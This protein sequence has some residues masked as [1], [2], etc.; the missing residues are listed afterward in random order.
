MKTQNFTKSF[1]VLAIA[2]LLAVSTAN[3][4]YASAKPSG[5]KLTVA[6][7]NKMYD[8]AVEKTLLWMNKTPFTVTESII[9]R[10]IS[11]GTQTTIDKLGS[12]RK[13]EDGVV[14]EVVIG[15][16]IYIHPDNVEYKIDDFAVETAKKLGLTLDKTW[17]KDTFEEKWS[18][19]YPRLYGYMADEV[20]SS[21]KGYQISKAEPN[22]QHGMENLPDKLITAYWYP[23]DKSNGTLKIS[24]KADGSTKAQS[25]S[26]VIEK[27]RITSTTEL[28]GTSYQILTKYQ[29]YD[30]TI[31]TP[32]GPYLELDQIRKDL[33][34]Q[35]KRTEY[36]AK[37]IANAITK[38]AEIAAIFDGL[39]KPSY[40]NYESAIYGYNYT[41]I[42][43]YLG[44]M[45]I[46]IVYGDNDYIYCVPDFEG[47]SSK[48][49]VKPLSG[50]CVA[51][52]F[53]ERTS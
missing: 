8:T 46:K 3:L 38:D 16:A 5:K 39:E 43:L 22:M 49:V 7:A 1:T 35:A 27:G 50:S 17:A 15:D 18:D 9:Q 47:F 24:S 30:K 14:Y 37:N 11:Y 20:R 6:A 26:V 23:K 40:A 19:N 28:E 32:V 13:S 41:G 53:T 52:G 29:L 10:G 4:S 42:T 33:E 31:S 21:Y 44:A 12:I 45:E 25:L 48:K 36:L 34:Y 51:A 2:L